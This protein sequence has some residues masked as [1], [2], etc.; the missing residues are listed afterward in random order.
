MCIVANGLTRNWL[1]KRR[2]VGVPLT[3]VVDNQTVE[4]PDEHFDGAWATGIASVE[5]DLDIR[6]GCG[7]TFSER[8]DMTDAS[9][10]TWHLV[11]V[12]NKPVTKVL[13]FQLM[14]GEEV[15]YDFPS[16]WVHTAS[17]RHGQVQIVPGRGGFNA[18]VVPHILQY[19][20][21][22]MP[23]WYRIRY[24]AGFEFDATGT[25]SA[26]ADSTTV[27]GI[28]TLFKSE[29]RRGYFI[30]V[31]GVSRYIKLVKSDTE[32]IVEEAFDPDEEVSGAVRGAN[33]PADIL[34][35]AALQAANA[36][37]HT[38]GDLIIEAGIANVSASMDSLSQSIGTTA[39]AENSGYSARIRMYELEYKRLLEL[40]YRRYRLPHHGAI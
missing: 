8:Y 26:P 29:F 30:E 32:L 33:P 25:A 21:P 38:A 2:L 39:S 34:D 28:G 7:D 12:M 6:L 4:Y 5:H 13:S 1:A 37:L 18:V 11:R 15:F 20:P 19:Y 31:G 17:L 23:G 14:Y 27:T 35:M 36:I 24:T 40:N 3:Y 9:E 16:S 10:E 22:Y